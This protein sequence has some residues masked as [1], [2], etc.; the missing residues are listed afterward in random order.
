[1]ESYTNALVAENQHLKQQLQEGFGEQAL[2]PALEEPSV[3]SPSVTS[4][5]TSLPDP[6]IST[7]ATRPR[8]ISNQNHSY[9]S[10]PEQS[11]SNLLDGRMTWNLIQSHWLYK[12]GYIRIEDVYQKLKIVSGGNQLQTLRDRAA[13]IHAIESC[14]TG[15]YHESL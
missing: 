7:P 11:H 3:T 5:P 1:L 12:R 10:S 14:A 8:K 6:V 15:K 13:V 4:P 9:A 2:T